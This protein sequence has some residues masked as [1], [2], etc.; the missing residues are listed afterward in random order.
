MS[1]LEQEQIKKQII[2]CLIELESYVKLTKTFSDI[3]KKAGK[4][5][6]IEQRDAYLDKASEYAYE[7]EKLQE[8]I[9]NLK[10]KIK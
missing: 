9:K 6:M 3:S 8:K 1:N 2:F 10:S 7:A 4:A 5:E